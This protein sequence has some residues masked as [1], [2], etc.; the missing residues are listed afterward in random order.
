ME[1]FALGSRDAETIHVWAYRR[2][3]LDAVLLENPQVLDVLKQVLPLVRRLAEAEQRLGDSPELPEAPTQ[4]APEDI[5]IPLAGEPGSL[6]D[7][8]GVWK[9]LANRIA[10]NAE[11]GPCVDAVREWSERFRLVDEWVLD[12]AVS[13]LEVWFNWP[14]SAAESVWHY[15]QQVLNMQP[16]AHDETQLQIAENWDAPF[17]RWDAF[18]KRFDAGVGKEL[19]E[20][21]SRIER[22]VAER[23]WKTV[24]IYQQDHFRWLAQYQV[25]EW[26]ARRIAANQKRHLQNGEHTVSKAVMTAA[27]KIGLTLRQGKRA[28]A[29]SATGAGVP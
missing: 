27:K 28:S 24:S 8:L 14:G 19:A 18:K 7:T 4:R 26:S 10:V 1:H 23:G 20:Y 21:K 22:L 12:I 15:P 17:E 6:P 25:R 29:G 13:T 16:L 2:A 5:E 9:D 3:F 11:A